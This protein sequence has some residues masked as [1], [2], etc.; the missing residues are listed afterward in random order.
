MIRIGHNHYRGL[1]EYKLWEL[2]LRENIGQPYSTSNPSGDWTHR[3]DI[4]DFKFTN[5]ETWAGIFYFS[6]EEDAIA[7]RLKFAL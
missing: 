7:F 4:S 1:Q 5:L 3:F 6:Y 2:W